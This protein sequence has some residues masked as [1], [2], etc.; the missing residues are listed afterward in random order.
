MALFQKVVEST[1]ADDV[2]PFTFDLAALR[3][4]HLGLR[5]RALTV[6]VNRNAAE[7]MEDAHPLV[8]PLLRHSNEVLKRTLKPGRHHDAVGMPYR[9]EAL[10]ITGIAPH[11]P[12]FQ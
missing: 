3:D 1:G 2:G 11:H 12:V 7:K 8:P 9:S 4:R 6:E 10:P 5:N